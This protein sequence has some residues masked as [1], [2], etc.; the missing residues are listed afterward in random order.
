MML[1]DNKMVL[2]LLIYL[3]DN[4]LFIIFIVII[5]Y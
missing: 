4:E 5:S 1:W 2:I 3:L